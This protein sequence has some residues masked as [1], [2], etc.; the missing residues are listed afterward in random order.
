M[1]IVVIADDP[2]VASWLSLWHGVV[3]VH[4]EVATRTDRLI[5]QADDEVV[6]LGHATAGDRIIA[7]G[8]APRA[9]GTRAY[10]IEYHDLT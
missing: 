7:V 5:R 4:R 10:F 1:P 8:S 6:R 2:R 3:P 9:N